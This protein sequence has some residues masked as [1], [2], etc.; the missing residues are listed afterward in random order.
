[1]FW[2]ATFAICSLIW[3]V[4]GTPAGTIVACGGAIAM[5]TPAANTSSRSGW[6]NSSLTGMNPTSL[7]SP[8]VARDD[9]HAGERRDDHR[10][11]ERQDACRPPSSISPS[12]TS[13]MHGV[14]QALDAEVVEEALDAPLGVADPAEAEVAEERLGGDEGDRRDRPTGRPSRS[15]AGC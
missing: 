15:G 14:G 5:S 1:M 6:R 4:F 8:A 10:E 13:A 2:A 7:A 9:L 3:P 12:R 11:G